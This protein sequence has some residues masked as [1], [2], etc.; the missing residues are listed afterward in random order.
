MDTGNGGSIDAV[1]LL[2]KKSNAE[3]R[4]AFL[5]SGRWQNFFPAIFDIAWSLRV[6]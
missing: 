5:V 6:D 3:T 1:W 4:G 2:T